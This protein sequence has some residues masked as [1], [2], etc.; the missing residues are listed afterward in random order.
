MRGYHQGVLLGRQSERRALRELID[1]VRDGRS[2]ALVI[3]GEPGVG[4][5]ALLDDLVAGSGDLAVVRVT[6]VQS[7]MEL[8]YAALHQVC[9]PLLDRLPALP[10]PQREALARVFGIAPGAAPDRFLVALAVL[11][12]LAEAATERPLVCVVDD[13]QWLDRASAQAL[14]FVARRLAAESVALVFAV[15]SNSRAPELDGLPE[16]EVQGLASDDAAALLASVVRASI[17]ER[18]RDR[19]VAETRGNPLAILELPKSLTADEIASGYVLPA[20]HA[21]AGELEAGFRGRL[22]GLPPSTRLL[23]LIAAAE[24]FGD[25]AAVAR[26]AE[27]LGLAPDAAAAAVRSGLCEPGTGVRFRHP[28]VRSA[29]YRAS[30]S[31]DLR[32]V[33]RAL[34]TVTDAAADPDRHAWHAARA[35]DGPDEAAAARLERGAERSLVRGAPASAATFLRLAAELTPDPAARARRELAGAVAELSAGELESASTLLAAAEAGPLGEHERRIAAV[36]RARMSFA[37][38]RGGVA[39]GL[40]LDAA[41]ALQPFD[42]AAAR[43]AYLEALGATL[44]AGPREGAAGPVE[45]ARRA[46]AGTRESD[47]PAG[48]SELLLRGIA[49]D[50]PAA[51]AELLHRALD[52]YAGEVDAKADWLPDNAFA[53]VAAAWLWDDARWRRFSA[54]HVEVVRAS[55]AVGDLP[56]ALVPRTF[57]TTFAGEFAAAAALADE[58]DT[59]AEVTGTRLVPFG[60]VCLAAWRGDATRLAGLLASHLDDA[61]ARGEGSAVAMLSWADALHRNAEGRFDLALASARRAAG[62]RQPLDSAGTWGLVELVEAAARTGDAAA[63]A[64]ALDELSTST[65]EAGTDWAL[66]VEARC[67]A[68]AATGADPE[69]DFREAVDRLG[70]TGMLTEHARAHL[71]YGEWLRRAQRTRDAR[72]HLRAAHERFAEI[73][74][75]EFARRAA[76]ELRATGVAPRGDRAGSTHELTAQEEQ[77][78][79]LAISG[80]SNPEIAGRLFLSTRTVEYHLHKVFTKLRVTSRHQLAAALPQDARAAAG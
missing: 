37:T 38:E 25:A 47:R 72:T 2:R 28:L 63:A 33:H 48:G 74:A 19:I 79:R 15:R 39:V 49:H 11:G 10:V 20:G 53:A 6:G 50:A 69:D 52:A 3:R 40:L 30:S 70:R 57:A 43:A 29:V 51:R 22:L 75:A 21:L 65:R 62:L 46:S 80:L 26:A 35:A 60:T 76:R 56:L 8:A 14:A 4:K 78:A 7:E 73:G 5:T 32:R 66:G 18:A 23:L 42:P 71:V 67:R 55:G 59:L 61:A 31:D 16:L 17:D 36:Q 77:V 34:A 44:F 9:A 45:V 12:L 64:S 68:L 41:G 58:V 1:E 27:A 13:A 24:P 54:H